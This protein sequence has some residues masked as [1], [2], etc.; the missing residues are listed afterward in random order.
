MSKKLNRLPLILLTSFRLL[1]VLFFIGM[2]IHQFLTENPRITL[3][4]AIISIFIISQ[5]R[6]LFNQYMSI[7]TQFL[8]NLNGNRQN[9]EKE[10]TPLS[11]SSSSSNISNNN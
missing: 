7:E 2:I 10:E 11:Q 5:S 1:L 6:W 3:A 9:E 4:L 8:K